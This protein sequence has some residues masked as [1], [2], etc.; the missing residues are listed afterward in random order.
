MTGVC[1]FVCV[2]IQFLSHVQLFAVAQQAPLS[3][4]F[5]RQEHWSGVPFPPAGDLPNAGIR[6]TSFVSPALLLLLS[7]FSRVR[8]CVTP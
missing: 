6:P 5:P 8:L 1:V 2:C 4:G 7:H 3:M